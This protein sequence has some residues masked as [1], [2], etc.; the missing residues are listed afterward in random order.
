MN[1]QI[2]YK[3]GEQGVYECN[4]R[5]FYNYENNTATLYLTSNETMVVNML[6]CISFIYPSRNSKI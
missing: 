2:N 5:P 1:I 4:A 6:E 3:N